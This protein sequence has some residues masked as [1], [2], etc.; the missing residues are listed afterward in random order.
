[1][2]F[3]LATAGLLASS[4]QGQVLYTTLGSVYSQ[5]F[6]TP[7]ARSNSTHAWTDN[8]TFV[9]WYAASYNSTTETFNSPSNFWAS[10]GQNQG[11]SIFIWYRSVGSGDNA[12]GTQ[13]TDS[14]NPGPNGT[15]GAYY[16]VEIRNTSASV[17]TEFT[18]GYRVEQ[19]RRA[20][21]DLD[22]FQ[23]TLIAA[24]RVTAPDAAFGVLT[25]WTDIPGSE[26]T[27]PK[28]G[29]G[30]TA[31]SINGNLAENVVTFSN[32]VVSNIELNPGT[33][34]GSAGLM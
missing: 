5:D 12:L 2:L 25:G 28:P 8:D 19:W 31:V 32:L 11:D 14:V 26:Y 3:A 18:I 21:G 10:N 1:M 4:A 24:Y 23:T 16:G 34:S 6:D 20:A 22:V 29:N 13:P 7:S 9:G 15:S 27:T 17:I 33:V 30:G